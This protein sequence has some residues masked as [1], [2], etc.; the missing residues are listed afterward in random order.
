MKPISIPPWSYSALSTFEICPKQ[1][2]HKYILK[3]KEPETAVTVHGTE[4]HKALEERLRDKK[5]L[6]VHYKEYESLAGSIEKFAEGGELFVEYP[7]A[8]GKDFKPVGFF[9]GGVWGRGKADVVIKKGPKLWVGD[10]KTG[11]IR[12]KGFQM[13][14]FA[15]FLFKMFPG[16][17]DIF[18]NNIW[19]ND[20][21]LGTNYKFSRHGVDQLW[22][23]ILYKI[24]R[25]ELVAEREN[26]PPKQSGLCG[27]CSVKSCPFNTNQGEK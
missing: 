1:Y 18:G 11:K 7:L 4:V 23:D 26:F 16:V 24:G 25:I 9:D 5:P 8:L 22:L 10:W 15:A 3:E 13:S 6:P 19:L 21:K 14:V 17:T 20:N 27:W 12:E 2:Y